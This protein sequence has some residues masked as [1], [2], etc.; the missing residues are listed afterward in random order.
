V[1]CLIRWHASFAGGDVV[2]FLSLLSVVGMVF[3]AMAPKARVRLREVVLASISQLRHE[4][5]RSRPDI[6]QF[7]EALRA[8]TRWAFVTPAL[9]AGNVAVFVLMLAGAGAIGD[10]TT[11]AGWGGNYWLGT[12]NG[13]WWRLVTSM[14]VHSGMFHLLVNVA[15]LTQLGLILERRVGRVIVLAV[16]LTAGVFASLV[17]LITHPLAMSVGASGAI[18]GLYGLL[19]ASSIWGMRHRSDVT[20]PLRAATRLVPAAVVFI[21]YN[22]ANDSVG[23]AGEFTGLFV[24]LVCGAILTRGVSDRKPAAR[25][26]VHVTAAAVVMAVLFAIPLRGITDVKPELER[27]VAAEDRMAVTYQKAA[28]RFRSGGMTAE[29][30]ALLIDRTIIPELRITDARL[31]A[32]VGVPEEH[33][34]LVAKAEEYVRL[35]SESWRLRSEWLRTAGRAPLRGSESAQYRANG[36]TIARA[37]ETQRAAL[38]ALERIRRT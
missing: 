37:E 38:A 22:L 9:I 34:P 36:R 31:K 27:T 19:A 13:E 7:R 8:R 16:F 20:I 18:F 24:G 26:V 10:P 29:A 30:L 23:A 32:L 21:L 11:L 1:N 12:R 2:A 14:F 15:G 25:R 6:D 33:Q 28:D 3:I 4:A 5:A 35:R 17:N